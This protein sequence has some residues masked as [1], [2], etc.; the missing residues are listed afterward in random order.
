MYSIREDEGNVT[1]EIHTR[2][3]VSQCSQS[4]W[5]LHFSITGENQGK[6]IR[7]IHDCINILIFSATNDSSIPSSEIFLNLS[8]G[9]YPVVLPLMDDDLLEANET[10]IATINLTRMEDRN[11]VVLV[12][13]TVEITIVDDDSETLLYFFAW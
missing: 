11:C 2:G 10:F 1:L 9:S 13:D 5:M 4:E 12:P 8:H 6:R 7:I 3:G